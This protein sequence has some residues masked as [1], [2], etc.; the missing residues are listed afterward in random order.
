MAEGQEDAHALNQDSHHNAPSLMFG[1]YSLLTTTGKCEEHRA[2]H[3]VDPLQK[4]TRR[5]A[6]RNTFSLKLLL[7]F[8]LYG[9]L[10]LYSQTKQTRKTHHK[11]DL[12]LYLIH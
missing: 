6:Q 11:P 2:D 4:H 3:N 9:D 8:W 12:K 7:F 1:K 5:R 10:N